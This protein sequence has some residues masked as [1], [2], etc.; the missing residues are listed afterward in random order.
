VSSKTIHVVGAAI[1]RGHACLV[2]QRGP[3]MSL[4][5]QWEFP[6]GKVRG[7]ETA[8]A[9]LVREI[10]EEFGVEIDVYEKVG[11][12]RSEAGGREIWLEVFRAEITSGELVPAEHA[13]VRWVGV[14]EIDGLDWAEADV[15]V[16][17]RVKALLVR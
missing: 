3:Q 11:E 7:G 17:G 5:L 8:E 16:V 9:A 12:G 13:A 10:E 2:A 1:L 6:G 15:P 4:P 14:G